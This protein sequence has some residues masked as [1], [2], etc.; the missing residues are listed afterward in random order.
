MD[1]GEHRF[2]F[3]AKKLQ[4]I[5][6][7]YK[8]CTKFRQPIFHNTNFSYDIMILHG[9]VDQNSNPNS[10]PQ[11]SWNLKKLA[12]LRTQNHPCEKQVHSPFHLV[13]R[14]IRLSK[15]NH[16]RILMLEYRY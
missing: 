11:E 1:M 10:E 14:E 15:Q 2:L 5:G 6:Q 7:L 8:L 3:D 4:N 13:L 12:M 9:M 16:V